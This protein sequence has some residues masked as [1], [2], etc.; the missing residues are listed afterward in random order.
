MEQRIINELLIEAEKRPDLKKA[1]IEEAR[2]N[3]ELRERLAREG[4]VVEDEQE[5]VEET[6]EQ[7]AVE[8]EVAEEEA[9]EIA[10]A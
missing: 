9:V 7:E 6:I 5:V 2:R 10:N 3:P 8:V 1:L 4:F